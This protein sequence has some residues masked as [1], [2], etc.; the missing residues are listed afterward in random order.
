ML[1][2][3]GNCFAHG[4]WMGAL[5]NEL[6]LENIERTI[7]DTRFSFHCVLFY[8]RSFFFRSFSVHSI[9]CSMSFCECVVVDG[10]LVFFLCV[11]SIGFSC[12]ISLNLI[13]F[14]CTGF[15]GNLSVFYSDVLFILH[16]DSCFSRWLRV[17]MHFS[18]NCS[19]SVCIF[20]GAICR[21]MPP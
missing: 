8:F 2:I 13:R 18:I 4:S 3:L 17:N 7:F 14:T 16:I 15:N 10:I 5:N 6:I 19:G 12:V 21:Q 20:V 1:Y 11:V 9:K